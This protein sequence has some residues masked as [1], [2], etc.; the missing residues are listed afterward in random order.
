[1]S[2]NHVASQ[3]KPTTKHQTCEIIVKMQDSKTQLSIKHTLNLN[4]DEKKRKKQEAHSPHLIFIA[5]GA[6]NLHVS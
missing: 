4:M 5:L 2:H 3:K 1:M 6:K